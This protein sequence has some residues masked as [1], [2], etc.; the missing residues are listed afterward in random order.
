MSRPQ[1]QPVNQEHLKAANE[2]IEGMLAR[3]TT[4][5]DFRQKT[6]TN[7]RAAFA[8]YV[9]KPVDQI[10]AS[11]NLSFIEHDASATATFVLPDEMNG[12][13]VES[14]LEA[15]AGGSGSA[16]IFAIVAI[17]MFIVDTAEKIW[18]NGT[19]AGE[20]AAAAK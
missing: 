20:A 5:Y 14:E 11:F 10:P 7:P 1:Q 3:T 9:G 12:E 8:E 15:V 6:L 18:E 16:E 19:K 4:D 2:V 13:L 17:G